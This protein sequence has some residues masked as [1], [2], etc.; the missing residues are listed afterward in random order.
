MLLPG[1]MANTDVSA[2]CTLWICLLLLPLVAP[3]LLNGRRE[4]LKEHL[5]C[6]DGVILLVFS[7]ERSMSLPVVSA[8]I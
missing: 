8:V 2:M 1:A 3:K 4:N 5:S 6:R 7:M